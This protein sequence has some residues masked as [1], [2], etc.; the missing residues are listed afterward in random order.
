MLM[1]PRAVGVLPIWLSGLMFTE[2]AVLGAIVIELVARRSR[3]GTGAARRERVIA[4]R[5]SISSALSGALVLLVI[6]ALS[7]PF[8]GNLAIS[9]EPFH[10]VLVEMAE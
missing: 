5:T 2:G 9:D 7:N 3:A 6:V 8:E 1:E 4:A 10:R